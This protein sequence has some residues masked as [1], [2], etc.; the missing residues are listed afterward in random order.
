MSHTV[1]I[2]GKTA[3]IF[4]EKNEIEN[5]TLKQVK[6]MIKEDSIENARIMPD[7]HKSKNCCVGFTSKLVD[8]IVPNYVG[9]FQNLFHL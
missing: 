3:K 4:L 8:K 7:C 9:N 5:E 2:N 1:E 6:A